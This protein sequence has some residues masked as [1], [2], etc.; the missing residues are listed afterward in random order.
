MVKENVTLYGV[1]MKRLTFGDAMITVGGFIILFLAGILAGIVRISI[2]SEWRDWLAA[3]VF[4]TFYVPA[5][6]RYV[7]RANHRKAR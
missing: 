3:G 6:L 1:K 4:I 7:Y 2:D 5:M